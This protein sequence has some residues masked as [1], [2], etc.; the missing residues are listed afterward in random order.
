[1]HWA[2][3][4]FLGMHLLWWLF[5][6]VLIFALFSLTTRVPRGQAGIES[7]LEMLQRRYARGEIDTPEYEERKALLTADRVTR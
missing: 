2:N 1:M 7:P 3:G 4:W 5:W 6:V